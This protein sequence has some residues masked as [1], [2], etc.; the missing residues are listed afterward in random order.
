MWKYFLRRLLI[1]VPVFFGVTILVFFMI[2]LAPGDPIYM[3]IP[4]D[5]IQEVSPE[6]LQRIRASLG[7]DKPLPVR[8]LLWLGEALQGNLGSSL[9][10]HTRVTDTLQ[11]RIGATLRLSIISL[12]L[13]L[14]LGIP[15]GIIMALRQYSKL[16]VALSVFVLA[17]WSTPA[18]FI[19]LVGIYFFALRLQ[20]LPAFGMVTPGI[21]PSLGDQIKHL[22]MPAF[23]LGMNNTATWA[24]YT[25]A[26][27]LDVMRADYVTTARAKG[28]PERFVAWRH[29][30]RNAMLPIVTLLGLS[31]PGLLSGAIIVE[32]VFGWPGMGQLGYQAT[33][34]RDYPVL[35]GVITVSALLVLS[36]NLIT[37]LAYGFVDP[38][39]RYE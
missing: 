19:A 7:F 20:V 4:F 21:P 10:F 9:K 17:Q 30:F 39:I 34:D 14:L 8:Y 26:S 36:S 6:E 18:F 32:T 16:D 35:M 38:R 37:D 29:I 13:S 15:A 25:R 23:I 27:V 22:A 31:I 1:T 3:I 33:I 11:A 12:L 5:K 24:R 28:L 2:S